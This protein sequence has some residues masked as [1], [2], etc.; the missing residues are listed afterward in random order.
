[1]SSVGEHRAGRMLIS[2][3]KELSEKSLYA[4]WDAA[5]WPSDYNDPLET[6]F[7]KQQAG[8]LLVLFPGLHE[9]LEH[10]QRFHSAA[11]KLFPRNPGE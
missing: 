3:C 4:V 8:S 10:K 5:Q 7:S 11:G 1:V 2:T 6:T 9:Y